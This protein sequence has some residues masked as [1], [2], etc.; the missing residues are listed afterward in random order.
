MVVEVASVLSNCMLPQEYDYPVRLRFIVIFE[1]IFSHFI[2]TKSQINDPYFS[3]D[4]VL[5][6]LTN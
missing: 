5:G 4:N 1:N 6:V 2:I 3:D